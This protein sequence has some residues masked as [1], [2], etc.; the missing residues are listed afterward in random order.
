MLLALNMFRRAPTLEVVRGDKN[1]GDRALCRS[2]P[3]HRTGNTPRGERFPE[4]QQRTP[5]L[6]VAAVHIPLPPIPPSVGKNG[7]AGLTH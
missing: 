5:P 6:L 7:L 3:Q 4:I 2:W 1:T